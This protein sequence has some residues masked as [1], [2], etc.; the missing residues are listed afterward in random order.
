MNR[1]NGK[2]LRITILVVVLESVFLYYSIGLLLVGY[3]PGDIMLGFDPQ[4]SLNFIIAYTFP[5]RYF[6][7]LGNLL[8][9]LL[10][11]Y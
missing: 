9:T 6:L 8:K 4:K 3:R 1:K 11:L 10:P 7:G 5:F 2:M